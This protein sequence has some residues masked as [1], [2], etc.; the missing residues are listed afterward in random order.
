MLRGF[1][2]MQSLARQL[3]RETNIRVEGDLLRRKFGTLQREKSRAQRLNLARNTYT[4][5]GPNRLKNYDHGAIIDDVMTTGT[6]AQHI[7]R[8][9]GKAEIRRINLWCATRAI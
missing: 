2:H 6:T 1:D 7:S 8:L 3:S 4:L 5:A 9:L